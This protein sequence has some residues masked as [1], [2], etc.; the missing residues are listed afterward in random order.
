VG[1]S[2]HMPLG[3]LGNGRSLTID[4]PE[5]TVA[6]ACAAGA[7]AAFAASLLRRGG[8]SRVVRI[9]DGGVAGLSVHGIELV[10]GP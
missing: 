1:G 9:A 4:A 7:R 2:I 10:E 5:Q 6:V 3:R 8:W